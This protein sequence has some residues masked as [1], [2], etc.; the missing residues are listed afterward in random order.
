MLIRVMFHGVDE[1]DW[2]SRSCYFFAKLARLNMGGLSHCSVQVGERIYE[3]TLDGVTVVSYVDQ[4][5]PRECRRS[6]EWSID[7]L[8]SLLIFTRVLQLMMVDYRL[9]LLDLI[10]VCLRL[11]PKGLTCTGFV[12]CILCLPVR[13]DTPLNT[14]IRLTDD[15][16]QGTRELS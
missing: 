15:T 12:E 16:V 5:T 10:R 13:N 14:Y 4:V 7:E 11:K 1:S 6:I 3:L 9:N 8:E 2:L